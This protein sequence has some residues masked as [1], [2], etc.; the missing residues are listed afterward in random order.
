[1]FFDV[2]WLFYSARD[3]SLGKNDMDY[4]LELR[5]RIKDDAT[6]RRAS[7]D[8]FGTF[9]STPLTERDWAAKN[10]G[11]MGINTQLGDQQ[12]T[13]GARTL[14]VD[15]AKAGCDGM[16][17][18]DFYI[19]EYY[20]FRKD[21]KRDN[22]D[23]LGTFGNP[24]EGGFTFPTQWLDQLVISGKAKEFWTIVAWRETYKL[25]GKEL[26]IIER[27]TNYSGPFPSPEYRGAISSAN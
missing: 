13:L 2:G 4:Y 19:F 3:G 11:N 10:K 5:K 9:N 22:G 25:Q 15:V 18:A 21:V 7:S 17:T 16:I 23:D 27:R 6:V 24:Y 1:M 26:V 20:D 14:N 12:L 8:Y